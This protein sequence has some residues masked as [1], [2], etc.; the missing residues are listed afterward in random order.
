[1]IYDVIIIGGGPAGLSAAIYASRSKLKVLL[2]EKKYCGGQIISSMFIDNYPGFYNGITGNDLAIKF[3]K[4]VKKFGVKIVYDEVIKIENNL[5][6]KIFSSNFDYISKTVIIATGTSIKKMNI[7]GEEKFIGNGISFCVTC[8]AAFYKNKTVVV[9]G[10]NDNTIYDAIYLSKFAKTIN[11]IYLKIKFNISKELYK[12]ICLYYNISITYDCIPYEIIGDKNVEN[13]IVKNIY[14]NE[15]KLLK[16]DGI[17]VITDLKPNVFY[18]KNIICNKNGYI[19]TDKNMNTS[20][21][22]IFAC[23][24]VIEK[25]L[26]QIVTAVSDGA[27]AAINVKCYIDKAK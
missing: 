11:I 15:K 1:M 21:K 26:R 10:D 19:I 5:T 6:N 23:G 8:D 24:D 16:T 3:E 2:L 14:T 20:V 7:L 18:V 13:I 25:Q 17:F 22:S 9:V 4:H 27:I 12:K